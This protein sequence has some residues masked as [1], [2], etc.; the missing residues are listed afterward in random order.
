MQYKFLSFLS[1]RYHFS[2]KSFKI[3]FIRILKKT[4]RFSFTKTNKR[5]K[6]WKNNFSVP[7]FL[8]NFS[9]HLKVNLF[10]LFIWLDRIDITLIFHIFSFMFCVRSFDVHVL[11]PLEANYRRKLWADDDYSLHSSQDLFY[12]SSFQQ[13]LKCKS[14]NISLLKVPMF[15]AAFESLKV[16]FS[17]RLVSE[18]WKL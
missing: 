1:L 17:F 13:V 14:T 7:I 3:D 4:P 2:L 10:R 12:L 5:G 15:S 9:I 6:N 11:F 18:S 16:L 8:I